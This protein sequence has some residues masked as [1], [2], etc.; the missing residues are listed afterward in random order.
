M[1]LSDMTVYTP[2]AWEDIPTDTAFGTALVPLL[3]LA[4]HKLEQ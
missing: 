3:L 1:L 4:W 2:A